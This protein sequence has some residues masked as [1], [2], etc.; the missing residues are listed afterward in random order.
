MKGKVQEYAIADNR[1]IFQ[2]D[3]VSFFTECSVLLLLMGE[4]TNDVKGE[5]VE[6]IFI[7]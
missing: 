6:Y 1:K 4:K 3:V 7:S 2:S 5:K